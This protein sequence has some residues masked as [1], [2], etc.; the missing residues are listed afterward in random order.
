MLPFEL[1]ARGARR[2]RHRTAPAIG[3]VTVAG[4]PADW[5][6]LG[7]QTDAIV[8]ACHKRRVTL[9]DVQ[10]EHQ[11]NGVPPLDRHGL[12]QAL[13][14]LSSGAAGCLVVADLS[15]ITP[16][17]IDAAPVLEWLS[18]SDARL[19]AAAQR[20]DTA[21]RRSRA[22]VEWLIAMSLIHRE[23]ARSVP[24]ERRQAGVAV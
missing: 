14:R 11:L 19:I 8:E 20:I 9:L 17:V 5:R 21:D 18:R 10:V 6:D 24:G 22:R 13:A 4:P 7:R 12:R 15:Q 1:P 2:A 3:Y 23:L 16:S